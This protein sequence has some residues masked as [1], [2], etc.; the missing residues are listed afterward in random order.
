MIIRESAF[1]LSSTKQHNRS[2]KW[3]MEKIEYRGV[4]KFLAKQGIFVGTIMNDTVKQ[5]SVSIDEFPRLHGSGQNSYN[6][7]KKMLV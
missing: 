6:K 4:M 1:E 2:K 5:G 7:L 3:N